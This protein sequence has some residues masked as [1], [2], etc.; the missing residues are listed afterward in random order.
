[1]EKFSLG[2]SSIGT[3]PLSLNT[4]SKVRNKKKR[5]SAKT[6]SDSQS[7]AK[8]RKL[9]DDSETSLPDDKDQK[10]ANEKKGRRNSGKGKGKSWIKLS[11]HLCVSFVSDP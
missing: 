10:S 1:M 4:P 8:K 5:F 9:L 11:M 7:P 6:G 2:E 3:G